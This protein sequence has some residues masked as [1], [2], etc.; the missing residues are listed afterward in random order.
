VVQKGEVTM[1]LLD[2]L[3]AAVAILALATNGC[4]IISYDTD[5]ESAWDAPPP[6]G[7]RQEVLY[8]QM[9]PYQGLNFGGYEEMKRMMKRNRAFATTE[10]VNEMPPK[11]LFVRV[12]PTVREP[13]A[14]GLIWGYIAASFLFLLP[15]YVGSS[16]FYVEYEVYRDGKKVKFYEY[17]VERK[18]F[19]WLPMVLFVWTNLITD[20]EE[21]AAIATVNLFFSDAERDGVFRRPAPGPLVSQ[22]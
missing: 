5:P 11:G 4:A 16:G 9:L 12:K 13:S 6:K 15:A 22:Q 21:D 8:Y 3:A 7:N 18:A 2:S 10:R 19:A 17:T 14:P 1:R 20:D